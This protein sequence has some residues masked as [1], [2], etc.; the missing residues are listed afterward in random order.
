LPGFLAENGL[1][2][3]IKPKATQSAFETL[4]ETDPSELRQ[5]GTHSEAKMANKIAD[6]VAAYQSEKGVKA[7][8]AA[9]RIIEAIDRD[10][11]RINNGTFSS[12]IPLLP[13]AI[14]GMLVA[15]KASII[16]AQ[17]A[18]TLT[19]QA[20]AD[21]RKAALDWLAKQKDYSEKFKKEAILAFDKT[22][23][24]TPVKSAINKATGAKNQ[25]TKAEVQ[26]IIDRAYAVGFGEG[27]ESGEGKGRL[28]GKKAAAALMKS[29]LTPLKAQLNPRQI[30]GL[31]DRI[32]KQR[33]FSPEGKQRFQDYAD[34][35]IDD[36]N[37]VLQ[38]RAGTKLKDRIAKLS[39][40]GSI[41]ANDASLFRAFSGLSINHM[42]PDVLSQYIDWGNKIVGKALKP[43]DRQ[44]LTDFINDQK[45]VQ[46]AITKRRSA[47]MREGR[48]RNLQDEFDRLEAEGEL[49]D[50]VTTFEE[51]V[52]SKKPKSKAETSEQKVAKVKDRL[53]TMEIPESTDT[54][55]KEA[56]ATLK[57][58]DLSKLSGPELEFLD[59]ALSNFEDTGVLYGA[60]DMAAKAT[61]WNK[62][63]EL[64]DQD[65]RFKQEVDKGESKGLSLT[66]IF[67]KFLHTAK[68]AAKIRAAFIQPWLS[69]SSREFHKYSQLEGEIYKTADQLGIKGDNWNRINLFGFLNEAEDNPE[70]FDQ[71]LAQKKQDLENMKAAIDALPKDDSDQ[72]QGIEENYE[73]AK[74]ALESLDAPTLEE[75]KAKLSP[76]ELRFYNKLRDHLDKFAHDAIKTI[77]LYSNRPVGL[78]KNYWPRMVFK[79]T[80]ETDPAAI[81]ELE[82]F[83]GFGDHETASKDL[84]GR[85]K[86]RTKL[87]G[88]RGY[89]N[90]NGEANFLNG[91]REAMMIAGA[92]HEYYQ[93][94]ALYNS[95]KGFNRLVTGLDAGIKDMLIGIVKS[96]KNHG[97]FSGR[98]TRGFW[99]KLGQGLSQNLTGAAIKNPLQLPKQLT[100]LGYTAIAAPQATL[101]ATGIVND[102]IAQ[103]VLKKPTPL[104][105]AYNDFVNNSTL[106]LRLAI[107]EIISFTE[108][109]TGDKNP[110]AKGFNTI[111][112]GASKW[113]GG[114]FITEADKV[115][116]LTSMLAGYIQHQ[117]K[118][119]KLKSAKDFDLRKEFKN[120]WDMEAMAAAEQMQAE[121]N[122]ENSRLFFAD[123]VRKNPEQYFLS[124]FTYNAMKNMGIQM[125]KAS[126]L[127]G[128]ERKAALARIGGIALSFALFSLV[129]NATNNAI[130]SAIGGEDDDED[131]SEKKVRDA[132]RRASNERTYV[133]QLLSMLFGTQNIYKQ[134]LGTVGAAAVTG[135]VQKKLKE[136]DPDD[137]NQWT[138][139]R[140][141]KD[142]KLFYGEGLPG[143]EGL[144]QDNLILPL[145]RLSDTDFE[146][147]PEKAALLTAQLA[148]P[149]LRQGTAA[150]GLRK[151]G[152]EMRMGEKIGKQITKDLKSQ[153]A[154]PNSTSIDQL[155]T[156]LETG[157]L[158]T[159]ARPDAIKLYENLTSDHVG[160]GYGWNQMEARRVLKTLFQGE[161][162]L[163]LDNGKLISEFTDAEKEAIKQAYIGQ[164]KE[165]R[166]KVGQLNQ[167][168][169]KN[170]HGARIDWA[171]REKKL[172]DWSKFV[173]P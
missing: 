158:K 8:T 66:Q 116:S 144:I 38:E 123:K 30:N 107:P 58:T 169:V 95:P 88:K 35:V 64:K 153:S 120:G 63:A 168:D 161:K 151:V 45:E 157:Q 83:E 14:K 167:L 44:Q 99:T 152:Q 142:Y 114:E 52:A 109:Y 103:K 156:Q 113:T 141:E 140:I 40:S 32:A 87:V 100:A 81:G 6:Y 102:L 129:H 69:A 96:T 124:T 28:E 65:V 92:G 55:S 163:K 23:Q 2:G 20:Y 122:S 50:G 67:N 128:P 60:G 57:S 118:T 166:E 91:L 46:D 21:A 105:E 86:G 121:S 146:K 34:K 173:A 110:I 71:L 170:F 154:D 115:V 75:M 48:E 94:R 42:E 7:K 4:M 1:P 27:T 136:E 143:K 12:P 148:A 119:G 59:N 5:E 70:L 25:S 159:P 155:K 17:K 41:P 125:G 90:P 135:Y 11:D 138:K 97:R 149:F 36:A 18:G 78:V 134:A 171:E 126:K 106:A 16:A 160:T 77:E 39:N 162:G 3:N 131:E 51:Y 164:L 22:F 76:N 26:R 82:E 15:F 98:D 139:D 54:A 172:G 56:L 61:V 133:N 74:A 24:G 31:L 165:R 85:Q 47:K 68:D 127:Q 93:M 150:L 111:T 53:A 73:E 33:D 37:Y 80:E 130:S 132:A 9:D 117:V 101:Q 10:I 104:L 137:L 49:P 89:Y 145:A 19:A 13:Q 29:L 79:T 108:R 112:A 43:G 147:D 84:F 62:I 72:K